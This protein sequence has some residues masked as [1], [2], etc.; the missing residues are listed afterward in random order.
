MKRVAA[1]VVLYHPGEDSPGNI[2]SYAEYLERLYVVDNSGLESPVVKKLKRNRK[3][4]VLHAGRNMGIAAAYN[5]ALS[6][7]KREGFSY[8]V[9]MDQDS[10][11]MKGEFEDF[12]EEI[13]RNGDKDIAIF[14]P[15]HR[16]DER[17]GRKGAFSEVPFVMSS[18]NVVNVRTLCRLG[19]YD[20]KLFIDE[21]DH[22]I[23]L[24]SR[25]NGYRIYRHSTI[26]L[27]HRLGGKHPLLASTAFYPPARLYYILRNFLYLSER[28][29]TFDREFFE[30]RRRY[31]S[32]F[33]ALQLLSPADFHI[34][35]RMLAEAL[36][37][38]RRGRMGVKYE[39]L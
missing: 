17:S 33:I 12:L 21:V 1:L 4:L 37:D 22:E 26:T 8:L 25:L 5:L 10:S 31:L 24:R 13:F 35:V 9:T 18:G 29:G 23:S 38:A 15:K 2:A 28:Y 27:K 34:R 39:E 30:K 3:T 20:E 19:G 7:A 6:A 11:F 32:K 36:I 14:S 16:A